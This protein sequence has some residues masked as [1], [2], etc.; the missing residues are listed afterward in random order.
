MEK[1]TKTF[2]SKKP[3]FELFTSLRSKKIEKELIL[4]ISGT[5]KKSFVH[6]TRSKPPEIRNDTLRLRHAQ[7]RTDGLE[8]TVTYTGKNLKKLNAFRLGL[9]NVSLRN[10]LDNGQEE[11]IMSFFF[12]AVWHG[13]QFVCGSENRYAIRRVSIIQPF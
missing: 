11:K 9:K 3:F 7:S 10:R 12:K 6:E 2:K 13:M 1:L 8:V 4:Y 5:W